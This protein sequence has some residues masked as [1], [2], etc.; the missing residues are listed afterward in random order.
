MNIASRTDRQ[1]LTLFTAV[2]DELRK[3]GVVRSSNSPG[4]D[5]A[6]ALVAKA[7][8]LRL[9]TAST[10]GHDGTDLRGKKYEIKCRR[11]T[12]HSKSRQLS[13]I[14]GLELKHFDFLVGVLFD[15]DFAVRRVALIPYR[16]IKE[17]SSFVER[18]NSWKFLL[19]DSVWSLPGVRDITDPVKKAQQWE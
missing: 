5:Y 14:R 12:A 16:V 6:E 13:A 9:N 8:K 17:H 15:P 19:R 3:R 7:L 10:A 11:L 4:A 1:L 18:T 2:M